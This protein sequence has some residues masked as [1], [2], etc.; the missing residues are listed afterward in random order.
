M[1][2]GEWL[3]WARWLSQR[4]GSPALHGRTLVWEAGTVWQQGILRSRRETLLS[5]SG[6]I[7]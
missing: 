3:V 5:D 7:R 4:S 6:L 1:A 2:P